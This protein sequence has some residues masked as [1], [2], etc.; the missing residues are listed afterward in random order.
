MYQ[1]LATVSRKRRLREREEAIL[2]GQDPD[3]FVDNEDLFYEEL[4]ITQYG[5]CVQAYVTF[6]FRLRIVTKNFLFELLI[7]LTI[8][9]AG[10]V[11]GLSFYPS[12]DDSITVNIMEYVILCIFALEILMKLAMDPLR[13]WMFFTGKNRGWN[14]F[15][16]VIVIVCMPGMQNIFFG[17]NGKFAFMLRLLRLAR[18][19]KLLS[20][21][22]QLRVILA[23]LAAG[24]RSASYIVLLLLLVFYMFTV[25][26]M[27]FFRR[28]DPWE[29]GSF[30]GTFVTLA[31]MATFEDWTDTLYFNMYGCTQWSSGGGVVYWTNRTLHP[32]ETDGRNIASGYFSQEEKWT[33]E[34]VEPTPQPI[35]AYFVVALI[36]FASS[37]V[38][39]SM[40]IGSIAIAM[41]N[42]KVEMEDLKLERQLANFAGKL[43]KSKKGGIGSQKDG[44]SVAPSSLAPEIDGL[45]FD[46]CSTVEAIPDL[47]L[48]GRIRYSDIQDSLVAAMDLPPPPD[49]NFLRQ[50]LVRIHG[51]MK[52]SYFTFGYTSRKITEMSVFKICISLVI[53]LAGLLVGL[54]TNGNIDQSNGVVVEKFITVVFI[55]EMLMKIAGEVFSPQ[56]YFRDSWNCFDCLV[57]CG[58]LTNAGGAVIV[59]RLLRLLRVLKLIKKLPQ[60]MI[61]VETLEHAFGSIFWISL[62][63][64][65]FFYINAIFAIMMFREND[66]WHFGNLHLSLMT[67]FRVATLEDWTDVMYINEMGCDSFDAVPYVLDGALSDAC[68]NPQPSWFAPVFFVYFVAIGN[69]V[70]L[71]LFVGV[72]ASEIESSVSRET[73]RKQQ[74]RLSKKYCK[75]IFSDKT[76][77]LR[78][79]HYNTAFELVNQLRPDENSYHVITFD[80][81][82]MLLGLIGQGEEAVSNADA[83]KAHFKSI[84]EFSQQGS[85][86][87]HVSLMDMVFLFENLPWRKDASLDLAATK[88][89]APYRGWRSRAGVTRAAVPKKVKAPTFEENQAGFTIQDVVGG[90]VLAQEDKVCAIRKERDDEIAKNPKARDLIRLGYAM[91]EVVDSNAYEICIQC[92]VVFSGICVGV[93]IGYEVENTFFRSMELAFFFVFLVEAI[94]KICCRPHKPWLYFTGKFAL[95]NRFDFALVVVSTPGLVSQ[96][97][98]ASILRLIRLGRLV[99]IVESSAKMKVILY[100]LAKG[101]E[102]VAYVMVLMLI[103]FYIYSVVGVTLFKENDPWHFGN[104]AL[105]FETLLRCMSMEDWTDVWYTNYYGCDIYGSIGGIYGLY[106]T[107]ATF[108]AN[109]AAFP[110]MHLCEPHAQPILASVYFIT[111]VTIASFVL[112]SLFIGSVLVST[113][114]AILEIAQEQKEAVRRSREGLKKE[115]N[116]SYKESIET[117]PAKKKPATFL[118][119]LAR[120]RRQRVMRTVLGAWT[121]SKNT[122]LSEF[123]IHHKHLIEALAKQYPDR[124]ISCSKD[125]DWEFARKLPLHLRIYFMLSSF[126]KM[127]RDNALFS[128]LI[129]CCIIFASVMLAFQVV[130]DDQICVDAYHA[131]DAIL[132]M[133]FT[134]EVMIKFC[135]EG[136]HPLMYFKDP[137]NILDLSVVIMHYMPAIGPVALIARMIRLLRILK[138]LRVVPELRMLVIALSNSLESIAM[139]TSLQFLFFYVFSLVACNIFRSNDR[140]HFRNMHTSLM[141]LFRVATAEDWTDIMYTA[142]YGCRDMPVPNTYQC[143]STFNTS[144]VAAA[145]ASLYTSPEY[146]CFGTG[147]S[148]CTDSKAHGVGAVIFFVMFYIVGGL[149]FLNLFTGVVTVGMADAMQ[150]LEEEAKVDLQV[151][152]FARSKDFSQT[153]VEYYKEAFDAVDLTNGNVLD[154]EDFSWTLGCIYVRGSPK[155]INHLMTIARN[156]RVS[157]ATP[158]SLARPLTHSLTTLLPLRIRQ[159][160]PSMKA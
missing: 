82:V 21:Y 159:R 150:K 10:L 48:S 6:G 119:L 149:V 61:L 128:G 17:G 67:L 43:A 139:V 78:Y 54:E 127:L 73:N 72:V 77:L 95:V 50:E 34:C 74:R 144:D 42:I 23:G 141:S 100:G 69:Y 130:C 4:D 3:S 160:S 2:S 109:H 107:N 15:D 62:L 51:A 76:Y 145:A 91:Q 9:A 35:L 124:Y 39:L 115:Q 101:L 153:Q 11:V 85:A 114:S 44:A 96:G 135:A 122:A 46:A 140:F 136:L 121:R 66:P 58:G 45:A 38:M 133:I 105:A 53:C 99:R 14:W 152:Q 118:Q 24:I 5:K 57:I 20:K 104:I 120:K 40:F 158:H 90:A 138:V 26:G 63:L 8:V 64:L 18:V 49:S 148:E 1:K 37:L 108:A 65:M 88:I 16:F 71:S 68:V 83:L 126:A 89:Q 157:I 52:K 112:I 59:M 111:F 134:V 81:V 13:P 113:M 25:G 33:R 94:T 106:T 129:N 123:A 146:Q 28:N 103:V 41:S 151:R 137:W 117:D 56:N 36:I 102:A 84:L 131:P 31:R 79:S 19:L 125:L 132:G 27:M 32:P 155:E 70:L 116:D 143:T 142:Q 60:L 55:V 86:K 154:M 12:L 156:T 98:S 22:E 93:E 110:K 92:L 87:G 75:K 97:A 80:M 7:N 47:P 30:G 29:F 147:L